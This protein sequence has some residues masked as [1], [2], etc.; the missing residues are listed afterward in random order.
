MLAS[1][2]LRVTVDGPTGPFALVAVHVPAPR[3]TSLIEKW[4][5]EL[6]AMTAIDPTTPTV[7]AG[8]F[9]ASEDHAQFRA[10]LARGWTDVHAAKGCGFDATWPEDRLFPPFVRIDHV[11][12]SRH[13]TPTGLEIGPGASSDHRSVTASIVLEPP[14]AVPEAAPNGAADRRRRRGGLGHV[15]GAAST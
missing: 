5:A 7:L 4:D 11:L 9:N 10:L 2:L 15:T 14:S 6:V 1:P 12:V 8:D 3:D 13:F